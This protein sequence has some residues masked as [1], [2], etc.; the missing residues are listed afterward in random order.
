[1]RLQ[2]KHSKPK[3]KTEKQKKIN[4]EKK[5]KGPKISKYYNDMKEFK[6]DSAEI[7][8]TKLTYG[9]INSCDV[10]YIRLKVEI[11]DE[12]TK[13]V[14]TSEEIINIEQSWI[15][16]VLF[17]ISN[18]IENYSDNFLQI[19][20][21][22]GV[23]NQTFS[24]DTMYGKY[25]FDK[26]KDYKVYKIYNTKYYL[27]AIINESNLFSAIIGLSKISGIALD[28]FK[29]GI[30]NKKYKEVKLNF[31]IL[32]DTESIVKISGVAPM[33]KQGIH[34][35]GISIM[36]VNAEV[37]RMDVALYV[38][39]SWLY[40]SFGES[41]LLTLPMCN[42]TGIS[43]NLGDLNNKCEPIR[44]SNYCVCTDGNNDDIIRFIK[45]SMNKL[46]IGE[47][48]VKFKFRALKKKEE[49]KEWELE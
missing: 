41:N 16:L 39:C 12:E 49:L 2:V 14:K 13:Q 3:G 25:S 42:E 27:E 28:E 35:V 8:L 33:L 40:K 7:D 43:L 10:N 19:L 15:E 44:N 26:D 23:T 21:D 9:I 38:F 6:A 20:G 36:G 22:N 1:M 37:H 18:V 34:L 30:E 5:S 4:K 31:D 17:M 32:E 29:I 46:D 24:I 11:E 48:H 47:E 45:N